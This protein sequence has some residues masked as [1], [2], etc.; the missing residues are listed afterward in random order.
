MGKLNL[1]GL[2][3]LRSRRLGC[4]CLSTLICKLGNRLLIVFCNCLYAYHT[5]MN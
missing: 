1:Y 4:E 5:C 2:P 3:I